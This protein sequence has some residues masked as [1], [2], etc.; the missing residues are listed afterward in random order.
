M[1]NININMN[2]KSDTPGNFGCPKGVEKSELFSK[3]PIGRN[4]L[5]NHRYMETVWN[6]F[7]SIFG[8][9]LFIISQ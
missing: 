3:R 6:Y 8:C 2:R 9:L 7:P 4:V 1:G 5:S